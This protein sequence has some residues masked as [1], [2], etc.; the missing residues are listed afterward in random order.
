MYRQLFT[1]ILLSLVIV[2][3][4][5]IPPRVESAESKIY[6]AFV[7]HYHQ[8]WYYSVDESY[9]TLPWV[10]MHSVGNYYKM[11]YILSKYP[12]VKGTFTFSGSLLEML[13][14]Y[15]E[16]GKMD[17]RQIISWKI[18]NGTVNKTEVFSALRTP[19]GF[20]DINWNRIVNVIPRFSELRTMAQTAFSTCSATATTDQELIDCVV[21]QFT[22]GDLT[23]QNVV[24]LA[25]LFNLFWIDPV[26]AEEEYPDVFQLMNRA[27]QNARPN[28][29]VSEL[30]RVL[31]VHQDIMSKVVPKYKSLASTGQVEL[32]PVPY[33]H[34][35]APIIVD[36]GWSE[37]IEV[38]VNVSVQLF[39]DYFNYTP[40]GAW[41][42]EQAVNSYVVEA[43]RNAGI[44]WT[45]TDESILAKT[46]VSTSDI[47]NL[48]VPW[49]IDYP[50][51]RIYV[52]FRNT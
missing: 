1:I 11:A 25:T 40:R 29:T 20:F 23:G 14:D 10:R 44:N 4:A 8:P 21:N 41:P 38:H 12:D 43:F 18:V 52:F 28:F 32:I 35:L 26:V 39:R 17:V 47:N 30:R 46:G 2:G 37:D 49:Y 45:I 50:S 42:A 33:S 36:F 7:W 9:F 24:D 13:V 22:G 16:N 48:G 51:G 3:F 27:Y 5:V 34:P 6:V 15:V 31:E 19:G